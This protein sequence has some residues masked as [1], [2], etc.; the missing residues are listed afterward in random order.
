M[1]AAEADLNTSDPEQTRQR[2]A[3]GGAMSKMAPVQLSG[4]TESRDTAGKAGNRWA[5]A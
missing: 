2:E 3:A 1:E 4:P 5:L